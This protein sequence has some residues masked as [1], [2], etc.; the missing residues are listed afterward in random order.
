M[1]HDLR[2]AVR[3]LLKSPGFAA[4]SIVT[5]AL[6]IGANT[7]VL[8]LARAVFIN[9]LPF[10]DPDRLVAIAE[11]RPGSRTTNIP[12][13]GH[14]FAAWRERSHVFEEIALYRPS[15]LN[16]T[17]R[18]EPEALQAVEVS[19]NYLPMLGL[20][21]ALGRWFADGEDRVAVLSDRLWR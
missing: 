1:L 8:S 13:S 4:M 15:G 16:L 6:G 20:S 21:P 9:P 2:H 5:L 12:I 10:K 18:G 17:G 7:A 11:R 14:E 3:G 19:A